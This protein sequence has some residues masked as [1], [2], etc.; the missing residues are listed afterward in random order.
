MLKGFKV[1][2]VVKEYSQKKNIDYNEIFFPVL[3]LIIYPNLVEY[4]CIG[5]FTH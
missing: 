3:K 2:L 1:R 4:G 5:E